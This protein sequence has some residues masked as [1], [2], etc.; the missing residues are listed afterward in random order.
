[1]YRADTLADMI[2]VDLDAS[3][4]HACLSFVSF[5]IDRGDA[6]EIAREVRRMTPDLW[7]DGLSAQ[8]LDA[9]KR[10]SACNVEGAEAALV[11]LRRNGAA[12]RD[13]TRRRAEARRRAS[14]P[15]THRAG[16]SRVGARSTFPRAAGVELNLTP[17]YFPSSR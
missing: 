12:S 17:Q 1:V 2:E 10:A 9:V 3:V 16:Y 7:A 11:D 14:T 8:I 5:A 6:A 13:R 4:C 15:N